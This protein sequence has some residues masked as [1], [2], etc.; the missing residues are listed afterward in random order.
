LIDMDCFYCQVESRLDSSLVGLPMAVV[1]YNAW[2]GGGIIAVN[3]EARDFGVTRNM[4]GDAAREK[5]ADI[6]LVK[7]P[8]VR[9]KADLS[10][11]RNAGR[12]VIEVLLTFD[13]AVVERASV[14][15]AYIDLTKMVDDRLNRGGGGGGAGEDFGGGGIEPEEHLKNTYVGKHSREKLVEWIGQV[16]NGDNSES[17]NDLRLAVGAVIV[18][19]MRAAVYRKT[20]FRCSAGIAH[21]KMLAKLACGLNKPN[22]QTV[23]PRSQQGDLFS[24]LKVTKL[25]GLGGKLGDTVVE[26]LHCQTVADLSQLTLAQ[27]RNHFDEKTAR[28]LHDVGQGLDHEPVKERDLPKSIGCGKNFRG[29]E[30]LGT[31]QKVEHWMGQL[32]EELVERLDKDKEDN[33]RLAR[34]LH[35]SV[36]LDGGPGGHVSRAGPLNAS[37]YQVAMIAKQC[38]SLIAKTNESSDGVSWIPKLRNI[39]IAATKFQDLAKH[40]NTSSI[41]SFFNKAAAGKSVS[42]SDDKSE[43]Q[44]STSNSNSKFLD[45]EK[46]L[47]LPNDD[48]DSVSD[49]NDFKSDVITGVIEDE[50]TEEANDPVVPEIPA[51]REKENLDSK[52]ESVASAAEDIE[53]TKCERCEKMVSPFELPEHLDFHVA[54][55]LYKNLRAEDMAQQRQ[56][57]A[58][59]AAKSAS[60]PQATTKRKAKLTMA[61][62]KEPDPK[63]QKN[64]MAFFGKK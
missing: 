36:G 1:Q 31:K 25:R 3:Y 35:V 14:D 56:G 15:E 34:S 52:V 48:E 39:T 17:D 60:K 44:P 11:Y 21:N 13:G 64:I 50:T 2:K 62:N 12:E 63:K 24:G 32:V 20:Q 23:L 19:E 28:W 43:P 47:F 40:A 22:K 5:C 7:V 37:S 42:D 4:R 18:E 45:D 8:E 10:K 30:M 26:H 29:P 53:M 41:T 58:A 6:K 61:E 16:Q 27:L 49:V 54:Q 59:A 57:A 46:D 55:D 9:G 38:L 51:S 33:K